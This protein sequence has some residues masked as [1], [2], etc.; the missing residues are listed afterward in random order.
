MPAYSNDRDA[1]AKPEKELK[2]FLKAHFSEE[3]S[4]GIHSEAA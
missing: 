2:D 1:P 3:R 4:D